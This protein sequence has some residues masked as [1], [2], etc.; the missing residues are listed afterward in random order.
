MGNPAH[1]RMQ[2]NDG[3]LGGSSAWIAVR[4]GLGLHYKEGGGR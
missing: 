4:Q 3:G 1:E 2:R